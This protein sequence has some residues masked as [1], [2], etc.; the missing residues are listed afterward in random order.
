MRGGRY[1]GGDDTR[2]SNSNESSL[3]GS[4]VTMAAHHR[5]DAAQHQPSRLK[6]SNPYFEHAVALAALSG[7]P[8]RSPERDLAVERTSSPS[9]AQPR[10]ASGSGHSSARSV[11]PASMVGSFA[12]FAGTSSPNEFSYQHSQDRFPFAPEAHAST[13]IRG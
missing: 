5:P 6:D 2:S 13:A 9:A 3:N 4:P 8:P 11:S 7:P 10:S 1:D 12:P